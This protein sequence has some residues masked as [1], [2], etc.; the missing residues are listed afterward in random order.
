MTGTIEIER[1]DETKPTVWEFVKE[2]MWVI[3]KYTAAT[4]ILFKVVF[5]LVIVNGFSMY[6]TYDSGD[7]ILAN[8]ITCHADYGDVVIIKNT[9]RGNIIKRVIGLPG[10]VIEVDGKNGVVYR[11]GEALDE[12]YVAA[13]Q[14]TNGSMDGPVTVEDGH[15]FVMGD[16]RQDSCDS[17]FDSMGQIPEENVYAEALF[18]FGK[19]PNFD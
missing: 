11:N 12:P 15:I 16:N 3:I 10:D 7:L 1:T 9:S 4:V 14:Y 13:A 8:H 5:C 19:I 2:L 18:R 17:R 6:P